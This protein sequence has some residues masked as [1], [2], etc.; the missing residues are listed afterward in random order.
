MKPMILAVFLILPGLS[1]AAIYKC[2]AGG[3]IA[4]QSIPCPADANQQNVSHLQNSPRIYSQGNRYQ[5]TDDAYRESQQ[6][7][8]RRE[9]QYNRNVERSERRQ[10]DLANQRRADRQNANEAWE[11]SKRDRQYREDKIRR[12]ARNN[13]DY[14]Y[15]DIKVR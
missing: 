4:Y 6:L 3:K 11:K 12:K 5:R 2:E 10:R 15:Y 1:Q 8:Q 13:G 9:F 14:K 7:Q